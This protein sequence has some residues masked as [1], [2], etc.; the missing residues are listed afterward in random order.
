MKYNE[1]Q[2]KRR[3]VSRMAYLMGID[4]GTSSVK[5]MIMD[6]QGRCLALAAEGYD[7]QLPRP[8]FAEQSPELLW[9]SACKSIRQAFAGCR[10]RGDEIAAVGLTGQMHGL[11]TLNGRGETVRPAI[12]W[13]DQ[14]SE[15]QVRKIRGTAVEEH[16]CN[17]ASTGFWL[18]SL[19]WMQEEE[20]E[21]YD[22]I[23]H[24]LLPKDYIRF[25]LT[26]EIATDPSD[27]SGTLLY[28][29]EK[30]AWDEETARRYHIPME[31]FPPCRESMQIV[32]EV[33]KKAEEETGILAGT[34]VICGGGDGPMQ[35][36]GNGVIHPGQL[37]TNIGTASQVDCIGS[38][39]YP[40]DR[41]RLNTFCHVQP[42]RWITMGAGLNGGIVLKWLK[43]E[44]FREI[45]DYETMPELAAKAPAGADGLVFLPFLCGER[46]PYMDATAKG[47]FFGLK[48]IHTKEHMIRACMESVVY[49]FLDC[50]KV[51]EE[52][53]IPMEDRII[54]S[55]GGAKSGFWLQMQADILQKEIYT[56]KGVEEA[57]RGA[58]VCA[59]VGCGVYGSLEEGCGTVVRL[60]DKVYEPSAAPRAAYMENFEL[61]RKIYQNN[62]VLF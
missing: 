57:C 33:T 35:L 26:G 55:G 40:D 23:R 9:E 44:I 32:G 28:H 36:A 45:P 30:R 16:A 21:L 48:L 49:S 20:P 15:R 54:A 18:P 22:Q 62:K 53:G 61:Y 24:I 14:R 47:I 17:P 37:V 41:F 46:S 8:G 50:M 19:L 4:L 52:L 59:G 27:A 10:V 13:N 6:E 7:I 1:G 2:S 38:R 31:F 29:M 5:V 12:I 34:S 56:T 43:K 42:E 25:R 3:G 60:E 11:V 51:F 39:I 58:A